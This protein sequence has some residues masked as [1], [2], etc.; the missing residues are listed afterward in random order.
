M[1]SEVDGRRARGERTRTAVSNA[2]AA[3]ASTDGLNGI[4]LNQVAQLLGTPKSSI[5][6]AYATKEALQLAGIEA[7]TNIF[8]DE[9]VAPTRDT[10]D[11]A[12]M[13]SALVEAWLGYVQRRVLPGGCFIGATLAEQDSHPGPVREALAK[14]HRDWLRL[15]EH[16]VRIAQHAGDIADS[17]APAMLA[18]EIDALLAAANVARNLTD[19]DT[20]LDHARTLI[21]LRL[22]PTKV[23][24]KRARRH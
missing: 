19:D 6:A 17:P 11:G 20:H 1:G 9:V 8:V 3:L 23:P 21:Q 7:A 22:R 24:G 2:V 16:H 10:D 12:A 15:L 5:Q 18:F 14:A 13:L 4:S